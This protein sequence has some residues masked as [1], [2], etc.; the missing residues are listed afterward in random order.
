[1][2]YDYKCTACE[3]EWEENLTISTRNEPCES[4]CPHCK[5]ADAVIKLISP[6][7]MSYDGAVS[8]IRRAGSGWNDMLKTIKKNSGKESTI[9]HY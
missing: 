4:P 9:E 6:T 1:M 8:P 7:R 2:T 3:K 5:T